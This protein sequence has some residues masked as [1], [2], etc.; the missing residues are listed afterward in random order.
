MFKNPKTK[1]RI[2]FLI[3]YYLI[4]ILLFMVSSSFARYTNNVNIISKI[5]VA[6][7]DLEVTDFSAPKKSL[8]TFSKT[9]TINLNNTVVDDG[10]GT[11][12]VIPG[13]KGIITLKLNLTKVETAISYQILIDK[14]NLP[15]NLHFY[16]DKNCLIPIEDYVGSADVKDE[17]I[18]QKIYWSWDYND[19][20]D[21]VFM[22]N[23]LNFDIK[24]HINQKVVSK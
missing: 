18:E 13:S 14:N 2:K 1:S 12:K 22:N 24:V 7:F 20:D 15:N 3:S 8:L 17:S 19:E 23:N 16:A 11:K 10:Y 4:F 9:Q 6:Q 5:P 21:S